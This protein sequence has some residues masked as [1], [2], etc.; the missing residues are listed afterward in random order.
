MRIAGLIRN[1]IV[2]SDNGICVSVWAQGCPH[3]C[4]GCHNPETWS[5]DGGHEIE[6]RK[7]EE[8]VLDALSANGVQRNLSFLGGEPLCEENRGWVG[9]LAY[10]VKLY[11]SDIK[12]TVWTG[13]TLEELQELSKSSID[14]REILLLTDT[15]IDGRF[16]EDKKDL[17]LKLRGSSNQRILRRGVDF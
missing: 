3:R 10:E 14:L 2:D 1:D 7:L 15:L 6:Y 16:E 4:P 8:K 12:I 9:R 11:F 5:F 17:S 13:Y